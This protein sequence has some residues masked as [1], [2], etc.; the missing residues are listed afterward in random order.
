MSRKIL[1]ACLPLLLLLLL[2]FNISLGTFFYTLEKYGSIN[3]YIIALSLTSTGVLL[4]DAFFRAGAFTPKTLRYLALALV[5]LLSLAVRLCFFGFQSQDY[6]EALSVWFATIKANGGFQALALRNFSDYN[7]TYLYIMALLTYLPFGSLH[8]IKAVSVLFDY[9]AAYWAYR[10]VKHRYPNGKHP[11]L[12][13]AAVLFAPTVLLNGSLW[14]QCDVIYTSFLLWA[15]LKALSPKPNYGWVIAIWAVALMFKLQAVFWAFPLLAFYLRGKL[16]LGQALLI[17]AGVWLLTVL[18][19]F[20]L[21]RALPDLMLIYARQVVRYPELSLNAPTLY[22]FFPN[23]PFEPF[24]R[25]GILLALG[26]C[27][28]FTIFLLRYPMPLTN[29]LLVNVSM[30][31]LLLIPFLLPKMHE[32]YFFAADVMAIVYAFYFPRQWWLPIGVGSASLFSYF[33]YLFKA[34]LLPFPWLS[35]IMLL[36]IAAVGHQLYQQYEAWQKIRPSGEQP[37]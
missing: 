17:V 37:A 33:P 29:R 21:G 28:F 27:L 14:A 4:F 3:P 30:L 23:A 35:T 19:H 32:R 6:R 1:F 18:P 10:L 20:M 16:R 5:L 2:P 36:S 15:L 13:A 22:Q 11:L 7:S 25:A 34:E 12:A 9:A 24:S 8:S 31:S 26:S